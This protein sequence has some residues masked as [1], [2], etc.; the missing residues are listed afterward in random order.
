MSQQF[1]MK[2][3]IGESDVGKL[4]REFLKEE[5]ISRTALTDIKFKGGN[6]LVNG[7]E[8]NVRYRL[9]SSDKL[10]VI[11]PIESPSEGLLGED[12]PLSIFY[13]DEYLLVVNKPAGMNTIPSR[14]H[15]AGSLANALIGYYQRCGLQATTHIVT[16]LDRDTSGIVLI[17][18]HR[19]VHHLFSMMQQNGQVKRTYEAFAE[20]E[21]QQD[22]GT[23]VAPIGR[24]DD[25][26]I[27]REVR[28]DGQYACT[29]YQ[30][31]A[32]YNGFTHLEL[33]LETGRTH[34]IRVHMSFLNHPL[35]GD[36]L[37]G[38]DISQINRQALHCKKISFIH[39]FLKDEMIFTAP[40]PRDMGKLIK[41]DLLD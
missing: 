26:I 29:H 6:I 35:L 30:V 36:D 22:N 39:P 14:E 41:A 1:Q 13:E 2:W 19:H 32:R 37:Y 38:G 9:V 24:K 7:V 31:L 25:S 11:F 8:V 12:I 15:P 5:E 18:K 34:Q 10:T 4:V 23:I 17:A 27:E 20:G 16:R 3:V 33:V 28:K 21:M 40:L